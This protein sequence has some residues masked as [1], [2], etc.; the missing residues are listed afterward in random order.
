MGSGKVMIKDDD[1]D[2]VNRQV[3]ADLIMVMW[4]AL[5]H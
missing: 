3:V 5:S 1:D 2:D 4:V